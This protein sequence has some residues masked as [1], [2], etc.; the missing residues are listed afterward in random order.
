MMKISDPVPPRYMYILRKALAAGD[1][2]HGTD[3]SLTPPPNSKL[4]PALR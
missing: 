4:N 3:P 2:S 1:E